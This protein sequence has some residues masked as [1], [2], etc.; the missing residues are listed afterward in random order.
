MLMVESRLNM[1]STKNSIPKKL[2]KKQS[3]KSNNACRSM[4]FH[5][6]KYLF[7]NNNISASPNAL[8]AEASPFDKSLMLLSAVARSRDST[9]RRGTVAFEQKHLFVRK[10]SENLLQMP[11]KEH[12]IQNA[13]NFKN[14]TSKIVPDSNSSLDLLLNSSATTK[15]TQKRKLSEQYLTTT[16]KQENNNCCNCSTIDLKV[17]KNNKNL[18][19]FVTKSLNSFFSA[20]NCPGCALNCKNCKAKLSQSLN[21][22]PNF[23]KMC[24]NCSLMAATKKCG[25]FCVNFDAKNTCEKSQICLTLKTISEDMNLLVQNITKEAKALVQAEM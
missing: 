21:D 15:T 18:Y 11:Q 1:T 22:L 4:P 24:T 19:R 7:N 20:T 5:E 6:Q 2:Q 16:R 13:E 23:Q 25:D 12:L 8:V 10:T 14:I 17:S 9:P 3:K